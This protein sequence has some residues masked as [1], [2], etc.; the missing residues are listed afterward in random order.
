SLVR[1]KI[2]AEE[3]A[4]IQVKGIQAPVQ[5]YKV[6]GR[7]TEQPGVVI[8]EESDGVRVK[9]DLATADRS[10][11]VRVLKTALKKLGAQET[12]E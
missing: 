9:I 6:I 3:Q 10:E 2:L 4:L 11:V 7:A 12:S 8:E 1:D 5:T